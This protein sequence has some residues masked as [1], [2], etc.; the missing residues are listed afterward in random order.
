MPTPISAK[1]D[2]TKIVGAKLLKKDGRTFLELTDAGLFEGRAGALYLDMSLWPTPGGQY[3]DWRITQDLPKARRDAGERGAILGNG[4]N[5]EVR[6][7]GGAP[8]QQSSP[9]P[10]PQA[11]PGGEINDDDVPF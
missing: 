11:M 3:G 10:A 8:A 9:K 6:G 7:G 4:K 1:T 2:L 5:R